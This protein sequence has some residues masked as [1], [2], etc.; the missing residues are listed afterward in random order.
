MS[1]SSG[2]ELVVA[3]RQGDRCRA[4]GASIQRS[5]LFCSRTVAHYD[6][7]VL[8][9][10][11][12]LIIIS[13]FVAYSEVHHTL[14]IRY[15]CHV[16]GQYLIVAVLDVD[17]NIPVEYGVSLTTWCH[18]DDGLCRLSGLDGHQCSLHGHPVWQLHADS[19]RGGST[20]VGNGEG[21]G[22]HGIL[23]HRGH[24][25]SHVEYNVGM[26]RDGYADASVLKTCAYVVAVALAEQGLADGH[27]VCASV[28]PLR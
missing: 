10:G 17:T 6:G 12:S 3:F 23:L 22:V 16:V 14:G 19:P 26:W 5:H 18:S 21:V 20:L 7:G 24:D 27:D 9:F 13:V 25:A 11:G 4:R 28:K 1:I 2:G 15:D 8:Y